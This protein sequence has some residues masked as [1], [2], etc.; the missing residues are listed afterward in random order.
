MK[1]NIMKVA[2]MHTD[3]SPDWYIWNAFCD[4][5]GKQFRDHKIHSSTK[6]DRNEKDYC[7]DC[8][9]EMIDNKFNNKGEL[10]I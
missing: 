9:R 1:T 6:P 5:C 3:K 8:M 10:I 2:Y 7:L 4:E